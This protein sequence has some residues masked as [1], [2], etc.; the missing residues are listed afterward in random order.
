MAR[1]L[2][3]CRQTQAA[4]RAL[5]HGLLIHKNAC[6]LQLDMRISQICG[7]TRNVTQYCPSSLGTRPFTPHATATSQAREGS[8]RTWTQ[9][10]HQAATRFL[11]LCKTHYIPDSEKKWIIMLL[12]YVRFILVALADVSCATNKTSQTYFEI[13]LQLFLCIRSL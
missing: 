1:V 13:K 6:F 9:G 7:S 11:L 5:P 8:H 4:D 10:W 2:V 12:A 3:F